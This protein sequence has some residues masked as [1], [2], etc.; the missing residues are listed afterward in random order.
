MTNDLESDDE[1]GETLDEME[2]DGAPE[3]RNENENGEGNVRREH[4][5]QLA[6]NSEITLNEGEYFEKSNNF[7]NGTLVSRTYR[8][9]TRGRFSSDAVRRNGEG[10]AKKKI[11]V[12]CKSGNRRLDA[13]CWKTARPV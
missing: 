9:F 10:I 7:G 6:T 3:R 2:N 4:A 5:G 11:L 1:D 8:A 12:R 13:G